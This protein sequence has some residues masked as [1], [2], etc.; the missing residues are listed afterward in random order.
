[1]EVIICNGPAIDLI[2]CRARAAGAEIGVKFR[3]A[4]RDRETL[5]IFLRRCSRQFPRKRVIAFFYPLCCSRFRAQNIIKI[6][7]G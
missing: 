3:Y 2:N 1:M 4:N 7:P 5:L 6:K